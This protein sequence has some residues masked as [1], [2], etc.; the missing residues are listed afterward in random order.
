MVNIYLDNSATSWPKPPSVIDAISN[1]LNNYGG[2]PG[3]SGHHFT[4]KAA[5][6]VFE[7]RELL[8]SLFNAPSSDRVIFTANATQA[9]NTALFGLLKKGD[10]VIISHMEHNSVIRPLRHL[11]QKRVI[12]LSIIDCDK[13][14]YINLENLKNSFKS[15]TKLVV[16][17]HGSNVTGTI[18]PIRKIGEI[19]KSKNVLY[20]VDASQSAGIL[21]IDFQNDNIDILAFT[22]HKELYAPSG[23]GGLCI[24]NDIQIDSLLHGGTGS[25]SETETHPLFYPDRLEAGTLNTVGIIGLKAG[26]QYILD[27]GMDNILKK[28]IQLTEYFISKL[29][30]LDDVTIYGPINTKDRLPII[31]L[32]IKTKMPSDVAFMLD[33]EYGIMTRAGLHCSPLAHKTIGTFPHGTIRFSLS[34][35]TTEEEINYTIDKIKKIR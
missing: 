21:P 14:G 1:Y 8:A 31:S 4:I 35:F 9:I 33:K 10:H 12:E 11:E 6:E 15:N 29:K 32:N 26:L 24:K 19:C 18:Q 25:K 13:E 3:R 20:M 30:E 22:G 17:I 34:C 23:I 2:S 7:T 5:T 28:Q 27:Q 16:T